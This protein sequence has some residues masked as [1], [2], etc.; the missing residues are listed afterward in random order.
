V[1]FFCDRHH[2]GLAYSLRLT[3]EK[4]LGHKIFFPIGMDWFPDWWDIAKPY[5]QSEATAKQYLQITPYF[6][7]VDGTVPLNTIKGIKSTHYE[8]DDLAH[9]DTFKSITFQQFLDMDIDVIIASIPDHYITYTKLRDKYKPKAKVV[10]QAGNMFDEVPRLFKEGIIKNFLAST[11]EVPV[12]NGVNVVFYHQEIP[13]CEFTEPKGN[14]ISSLVHLLPQPEVFNYYK[15]AIPEAIFKAFGAGCPDGYVSSQKGVCDT[16][17]S[18]SLIFHHKPYADGFGHVVHS[19]VMLGRPLIINYEEYK[20]R[21]AGKILIKDQNC[22]SLDSGE[23]R[24][25]IVA[26]IKKLITDKNLLLEY[27][28]KSYNLFREVVN[29]EKEAEQITDFLNNLK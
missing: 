3:L 25:E 7:P 23:S 21:L 10:C 2:S 1:N 13:M 5:N 18:S 6:T 11:I 9:G 20:T 27:C 8:V 14:R 12:P 19:A 16:I 24:Q 22:I 17:R 29:Y 26:K 28:K 15:S 4:R